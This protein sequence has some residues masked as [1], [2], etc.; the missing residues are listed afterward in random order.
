MIRRDFIGT[1]A[2]EDAKLFEKVP[3]A[4][5]SIPLGDRSDAKKFGITET[6]FK[7]YLERHTFKYQKLNSKTI[8]PAAG[9]FPVTTA[10]GDVKTMLIEAL[11]KLPDTEQIG[12]DPVSK[13]VDLSNGLRVN[14][15]ALKSGKLSAFFPVPGGTNTGYHKYEAV[16][17]K[18]IRDAKSE[19]I[20]TAKPAAAA[21]KK[22]N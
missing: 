16:E 18:A 3:P 10:V 14:L 9:M 5:S 4:D 12:A 1:N 20:A 22:K 6:N 21:P 2:A 11:G 19:A 7:H 8:N 13:S 17:L 15:G